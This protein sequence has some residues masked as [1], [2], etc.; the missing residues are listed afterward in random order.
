MDYGICVSGVTWGDDGGM[1]VSLWG[2]DRILAVKPQEKSCDGTPLGLSP[3][4][5]PSTK[6]GCWEPKPPPKSLSLEGRSPGPRLISRTS[7]SAGS[8]DL[9]PCDYGT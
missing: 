8:I 9:G 2:G 6:P 3:Q 7:W 4:F 1:G 5:T